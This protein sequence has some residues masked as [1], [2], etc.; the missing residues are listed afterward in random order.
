HTHNPF[1]PR[2]LDVD[3]VH[4]SSACTGGSPGWHDPIQPSEILL[5][6]CNIDGLEVFLKMPTG[7]TTWNRDDI[8]TL[9]QRF[10]LGQQFQVVLEV[11]RLKA[12]VATAA[13]TVGK[14]LAIAD[15]TSEEASSEG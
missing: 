12:R 14:V 8:V 15:R 7:L 6:Q 1:L 2:R 13:V 5:R 11:S 3:P 9:G 4:I 10:K